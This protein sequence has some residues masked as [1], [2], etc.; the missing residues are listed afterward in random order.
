MRLHRRIIDNIWLLRSLPQT[1][2]FNLRVLPLAQAIKL[3]IW[4][5]KPHFGKL[6]KGGVILNI[7][8]IRPGII[9]LGRNVVN[10]Y[11]NSGVF[12]DIRGRIIFN[13]ECAIGNDSA[14]TVGKT[15]VLQFGSNFRATTSIKV[16]CYHSIKFGDNVLVGW[17][18]LFMDTDFH[19]LTR[20][21]GTKTK[22]YGKIIIGDGVWFGCG[23]RV[24]KRT[25]IPSQCVIAAQTIL[26][27][28]IEGS[29]NEKTIIGNSNSAM[30][31]AK[32]YYR[33][34]SDDLI[35]Y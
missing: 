2:Y 3:P 34:P 12:I 14:I 19:S 1:I 23:C 18:C 5:Y 22:G 20:N 15:G 27:E 6:Y 33:N 13:G 28:E 30:V 10:I 9:K 17:D 7:Q 35:Y 32:G 29:E 31:L 26:K 4:L 8:R 24:F 25:T 11:P 16:V 21:D